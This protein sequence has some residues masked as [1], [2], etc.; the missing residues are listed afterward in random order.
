MIS[1]ITASAEEAAGN[2]IVQVSGLSDLSGVTITVT[3]NGKTYTE[4]TN[5]SGQAVFSRLPVNDS[6]GN[7][8][9]YTIRRQF[10]TDIWLLRP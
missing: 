8:I 5:D 10:Q 7:P 6:S 2:L 3:G 9:T 1:Q 4:I